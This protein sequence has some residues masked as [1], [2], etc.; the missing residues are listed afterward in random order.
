MN[1]ST[2]LLFP[3]YLQPMMVINS[4]G[5]PPLH[6][7]RCKEGGLPRTSQKRKAETDLI[8]AVKRLR[9]CY[10]LKRKR[11]D[12]SAI[13]SSFKR[14]RLDEDQEEVLF[15]LY[16]LETH[17][18][19]VSTCHDA[20]IDTGEKV[21][22]SHLGSIW[23]PHSLNGMVRR[24]QRLFQLGSTWISHPKYGLLRRSSRIRIKLLP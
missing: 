19:S 10:N 14:T 20:D 12:N 7:H 2:K 5:R 15:G 24:S 9:L 6:P 23:F 21:K 18:S 13:M 17:D 8:M 3:F 4:S 11:E 22:S 16:I 1:V